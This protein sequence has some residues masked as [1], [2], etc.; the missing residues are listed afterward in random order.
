M[1]FRAGHIS[2]LCVK[3]QESREGHA[4]PGVPDVGT[5]VPDLSTR[6]EEAS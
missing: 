5:S 6:K 3:Q 1:S 2:R 4:R